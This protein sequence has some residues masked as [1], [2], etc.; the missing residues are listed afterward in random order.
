MVDF[1]KRII[2]LEVGW[3][4]SVGD[5]RIW[6]CSTLK[7][8]YKTWLSQ[9]PTTPLVTGMDPN[10]NEI[11]E[12]VPPFILG[13]SAYPNSRHLVTTYKTTEILSSAIVS[14]LNKKLGG[15]RYHVENAF[16]ILKARF[17]IF[18]RQLECA[19]EDVC[20]AITLTSSI[21]IIH[22]FLIDINDDLNN[23]LR[24]EVDVNTGSENNDDDNDHYDQAEEV[25]LASRD[26][27]LRHVRYIINTV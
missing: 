3:P 1:K 12:D 11:N 20:L 2:D 13:D 10:E 5:G 15:A 24:P 6:A 18:K 8:S 17:Q 21:F 16:G 9:L 25:E 27:L 4:G 7:K 23:T 22:N 19:Q 26:I 14:E